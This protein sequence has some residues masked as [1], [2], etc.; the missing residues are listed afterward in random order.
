MREQD[1]TAQV[2]PTLSSDAYWSAEDVL[3]VTG[4]GS[5]EQT[6]GPT[7]DSGQPQIATPPPPPNG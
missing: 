6:G 4:D 1:A 7:N 3:N 2:E 5:I